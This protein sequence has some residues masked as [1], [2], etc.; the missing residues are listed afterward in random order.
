MFVFW[1]APS[2]AKITTRGYMIL[3][4]SLII[5]PLLS[6]IYAS[7]VSFVM[8]GIG[9]GMVYVSIIS[10]AMNHQER[11]RATGLFESGIGIGGIA[12]PFIS[13]I[14][15]EHI[16]ILGPYWLSSSL[17]ALLVVMARRLM[18]REKDKPLQ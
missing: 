3:T 8:M 14:A 1:E 17:T 15:A 5:L 16:G 4:V 12:G 7:A 6:W 18:A 9:L 2:R 11:G 10:L 13:G